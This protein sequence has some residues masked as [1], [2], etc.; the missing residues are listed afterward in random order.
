MQQARLCNRARTWARQC[1][2]RQKRIRNRL[3]NKFL[4]SGQKA[5]VS[6]KGNGHPL[7]VWKPKTG[8]SL[9]KPPPF[10]FWGYI[11]HG[12]P[13]PQFLAHAHQPLHPESH[14]GKIWHFFVT[15]VSGNLKCSERQLCRAQ[16]CH[17]K[18]YPEK[19]TKRNMDYAL[20]L[21][22]TLDIL[23]YPFFDW[24]S[25]AMT[26]DSADKAAF[27]FISSSRRISGALFST[28]YRS[29]SGARPTGIGRQIACPHGMFS[30]GCPF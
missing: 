4:N 11:S 14:L 30:R 13:F 15:D 12:R 26:V 25:L 28:R 8:D 3:F 21:L 5:L 7:R 6:K 22:Y 16:H 19:H 23:P 9:K 17:L 18:S 20:P 2:Y 1:E 27:R 29:S 10:K 24:M